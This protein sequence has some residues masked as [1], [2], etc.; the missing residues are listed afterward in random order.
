MKASVLG[1]GNRAGITS[2][3]IYIYTHIHIGDILE[4]R[5]SNQTAIAAGI[6]STIH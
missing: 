5:N 3:N 2:N 6:D 1:D 4:Q